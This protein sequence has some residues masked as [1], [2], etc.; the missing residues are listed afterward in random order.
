M[1]LQ[2]ARQP[3][4]AGEGSDGQ[5]APVASVQ[6]TSSASASFSLLLKNQNQ[7][8]QTHVQRTC[9]ALPLNAPGVRRPYWTDKAGP[10]GAYLSPVTQD[11]R[12]RKSRAVG[13]SAYGP[14][15]WLLSSVGQN[16]LRARKGEK[17]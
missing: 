7:Y 16:I 13:S 9:L 8:K 11:S 4:T 1:Y 10:V 5:P 2:I 12:N 17:L 3:G 15:A 14:H 6:P